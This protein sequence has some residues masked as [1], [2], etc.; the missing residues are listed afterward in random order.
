MLNKLRSNKGFTLIE[1]L[2]VVAII[3]I[4]AAVAIPQFSKYR[5]QGFNASA[6][7]DM[8]NVRTSQESLYAEWQHYGK[9]DNTA[10]LPGPGGFGAG[11][12]VT[13]PGVA[14]TPN[15]ITTNDSVGTARGIQIP[16]GNN[17]SAGA[18]T[19][20]TGSSFTLV[21]K[22]LQGDT[23][24]AGDS[25]STANYKL[26]YNATGPLGKNAGTPMVMGDV[27]APVASVDEFAAA[28]AIALGWK[29]I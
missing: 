21:T 18:S 23:M 12:L 7:S 6:N 8:R 4:L 10:A 14:A 5:I 28:A 19:D 3:G 9:T 24:Y 2:I 15:L 11:V 17:V 20:A 16:V 25:D 13:G 29:A 27:I 22:H 26:T 1:L